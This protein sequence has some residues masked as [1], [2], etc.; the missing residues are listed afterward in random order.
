MVILLV[1]PQPVS[2]HDSPVK[3]PASDAA[4]VAGPMFGPV[5]PVARKVP[6]SLAKV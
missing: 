3:S 2:M 5:R 4:K 1:R 6:T